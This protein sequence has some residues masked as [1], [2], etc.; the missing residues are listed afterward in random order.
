MAVHLPGGVGDAW[1]RVAHVSEGRAEG[2]GA[3]RAHVVALCDV[4]RRERGQLGAGEN[5]LAVSTRRDEKEKQ[6]L[7]EVCSMHK[8]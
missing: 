4:W 6:W 8:G 5:V 3:R 1:G 2:L 7:D